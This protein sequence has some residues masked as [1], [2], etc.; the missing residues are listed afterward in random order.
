[1]EFP[2]LAYETCA[3]IFTA[4]G[5]ASLARSVIEA[6][7]H[8]LMRRA[9]RISLP[10]WRQTFLEQVPEHYRLQ[11]CWQDYTQSSKA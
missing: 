7:Y 6:G 2:M 1:M 5:Q 3:D 4:A 9:D 11:G 10:E 8:E